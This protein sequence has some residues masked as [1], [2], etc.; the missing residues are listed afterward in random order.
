MSDNGPCAA[1][2]RRK[3]SLEER[4]YNALGTEWC[5][6]I[7]PPGDHIRI[8]LAH[9]WLA[10]TSNDGFELWI[11]TEDRWDWH[12]RFPEALR[13]AWFILWRWWALSTWFGLRRWLWYKLLTRR[14]AKYK[15]GGLR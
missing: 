2:G 4:L 14:C 9:G 12:C 8:D 5:G 6:N 7:N 15:R 11:G 13:L 1:I 3:I 10:A